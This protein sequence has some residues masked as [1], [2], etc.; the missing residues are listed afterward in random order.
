LIHVPSRAAF[1]VNIFDPRADR[2]SPRPLEAGSPRRK[3]RTLSEVAR[4][5]ESGLG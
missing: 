5:K 2:P 3:A 1:N 4:F